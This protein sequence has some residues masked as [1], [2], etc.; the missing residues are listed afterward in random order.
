MT[1]NP[2]S[3]EGHLKAFCIEDNTPEMVRLLQLP[4]DFCLKSDIR[5][6]VAS[7]S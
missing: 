2:G 7:L 1:D 4:F 5:K 3:E 6:H